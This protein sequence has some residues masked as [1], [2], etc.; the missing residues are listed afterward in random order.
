VYIAFNVTPLCVFLY[1]SYH[2]AQKIPFYLEFCAAICNCYSFQGW[3]HDFA[4]SPKRVSFYL[5]RHPFWSSL[6]FVREI[7]CDGGSTSWV[8][9][10]DAVVDIETSQCGGCVIS[11]EFVLETYKWLIM[12][13]WSDW[14]F[15]PV[16]NIK[17]LW[18]CDL[19]WPSCIVSL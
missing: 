17:L 4:E 12:Y 5:A 1:A 9:H 13:S 3:S 19:M 16:Q 2:L 11:V 15:E 7:N 10:I 14:C 18:I 6:S 8:E